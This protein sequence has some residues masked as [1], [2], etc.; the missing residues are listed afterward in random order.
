MRHSTRGRNL[1][2]A[3]LP[4]LLGHSTETTDTQHCMA[5]HFDCIVVGAGISGIDAAYHLKTLCKHH[6][7]VVLERRQNLGGK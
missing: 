4:T 5:E 6:S 7:F 3:N 2:V 1:C